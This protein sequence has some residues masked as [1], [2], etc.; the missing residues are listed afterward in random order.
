MAQSSSSETSASVSIT[1]GAQADDQ[2]GVPGDGFSTGS[3]TVKSGVISLPITSNT[4]VSLKRRI[5]PHLTPSKK[6]YRQSENAK[7]ALLT[8]VRTMIEATGEDPDREGL[9][10]TPE[11]VMK[12]LQFL[13][14]G[15][16][17]TVEEVV[18][19]AV[20]HEDHHGMV[21]TSCE[22]FS[23]CEHHLLPFF[24]RIHVA[25]IPR[26]KIVGLSKISRI[27]EVFS[28]RLSV[29]ERLTKQVADAVNRVLSPLGVAVVIDCIHMCMMARGVEKTNS[30]TTTSSVLGVF[31]E[32]QKTRSE[33]FSHI[34]N[35]RFRGFQ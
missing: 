5:G 22:V 11:R 20:F 9:R 7:N 10:K 24:G 14:Q 32:D 26:E 15:Y 27:C 31:A 2:R 8:S 19:D 6:R 17:Q 34:Q 13:T 1:R 12:S 3:S 33:F 23:M 4:R 35:K 29:Q 18:G 30:M 25:Y 16:T 28:R 21:I